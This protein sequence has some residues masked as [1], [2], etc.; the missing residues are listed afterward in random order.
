VAAADFVLSATDVAVT[1]TSVDNGRAEGAVYVMAAPEALDSA[2]SVP[3]VT[4]PQLMPDRVQFT[5][6]FCASFRT[7]AV[8]FWLPLVSRI[9]NSG[10]MVT[11][12]GAGAAVT[13]A[14]WEKDKR[15]ET[16]ATMQTATNRV[17]RFE[18]GGIK[19]KSLLSLRPNYASGG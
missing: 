9:P 13:A 12:I 19:E 5:P 11:K 7:V 3:Q 6:L 4:L 17:A 1:V 18:K 16:N 15:A 2:E 10:E 8:K 14:R